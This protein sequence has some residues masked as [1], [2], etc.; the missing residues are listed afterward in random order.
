MV[1][2]ILSSSVVARINIACVGGSSRVL[3][4]ASKAGLVSWWASSIMKTLF[5][6]EVGERR[7]PSLR[8]RISS[9][10]RL[11]AASNSTTSRALPSSICWQGR[12]LL[13]GS[14]FLRKASSLF[15]V[16]QLAILARI[17]AAVV[18]PV[19]LGPE[20]RYAWLNLPALA[21]FPR[22]STTKSWPIIS[23][24]VLGRYFLYIARVMA[25]KSL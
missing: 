21:A 12:H 22:T 20:K 4:S 11:L 16:S 7:M 1:G 5:L 24:R 18:L 14:P 10:P 3:R 23:A 6:C 2:G 8:L 15:L 9:I 17:L 19:P 13:Q 25:Q